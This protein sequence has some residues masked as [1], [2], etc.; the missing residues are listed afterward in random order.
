LKGGR[1]G[2]EMLL[3]VGRLGSREFRKLQRELEEK[4]STE[5]HLKQTVEYLDRQIDPA[6]SF[7]SENVSNRA[8]PNSN[9][10]NGNGSTSTDN[11]GEKSFY[12][13]S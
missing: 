12:F 5:R 13:N 11:D 2:L 9:R 4:G 10:G 8:Q 1:Q 7:G 6:L 3:L